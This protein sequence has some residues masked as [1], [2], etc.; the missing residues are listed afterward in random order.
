MTIKVLISFKCINLTELLNDSVGSGFCSIYWV[1]I[2]VFTVVMIIII[3]II[4]SSMNTNNIITTECIR[5][6][7][8]CHYPDV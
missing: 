2:N 3:I 4:S 8:L 6:Q 7:H 5:L 1:L